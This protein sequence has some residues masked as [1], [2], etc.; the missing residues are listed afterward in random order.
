M[1][2]DQHQQMDAFVRV[3]ERSKF[4]N[5]K[6]KNKRDLYCIQIIHFL[7]SKFDVII[8]LLKKCAITYSV[9]RLLSNIRAATWE[10]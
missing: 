8:F 1:A 6:N 2:K 7:F 5:G 4:Q 10:F 3:A 9:H